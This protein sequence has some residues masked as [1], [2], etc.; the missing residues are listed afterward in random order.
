M[1]H[2]HYIGVHAFVCICLLQARQNDWS[3]FW[4]VGS[5]KSTLLKALAGKLRK[6]HDL[7][8]LPPTHAVPTNARNHSHL[9]EL[10]TP[11]PLVL[12]QSIKSQHSS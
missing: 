2:G 9:V 8:V 5:G 10:P 3:L 11:Q 4:P 1:I 7:K 12:G 6:Q